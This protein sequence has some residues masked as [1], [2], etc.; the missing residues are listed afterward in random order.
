MASSAAVGPRPH[1]E[2]PSRP[3]LPQSPDR[4]WVGLAFRRR[5]YG[6]ARRCHGEICPARDRGCV[7]LHRASVWRIRAGHDS[8]LPGDGSRT[9]DSCRLRSRCEQGDHGREP[10]F[11]RRPRAG[12]GSA[13]SS[14][15]RSTHNGGRVGVFVGP[16]A[17]RTT[18]RCRQL[19]PGHGIWLGLDPWVACVPCGTEIPPAFAR[20][21]AGGHLG[22]HHACRR[23]SIQYR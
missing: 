17:R 8:C 23:T 20:W 11:H 1:D 12:S 22:M 16:Q 6:L 13:S 7:D 5:R 18:R 14:W 2:Q 19:R 21:I 10:R 9:S 3:R 15:R 4:R